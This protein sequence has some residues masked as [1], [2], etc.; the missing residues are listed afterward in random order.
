MQFW[1]ISLRVSFSYVAPQS[2]GCAL[3]YLEYELP[4]A[5]LSKCANDAIDFVNEDVQSL[6]GP[7]LSFAEFFD[8]L[9]NF[10]LGGHQLFGRGENRAADHDQIA[11]TRVLPGNFLTLALEQLLLAGLVLH[12][13]V[14]QVFHFGESF[15]G[16]HFLC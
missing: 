9:R 13:G 11:D 12:H 16:C 8:L 5:V 10:V 3:A 1:R 4:C 7:G 2:R 15:F 14:K 6:I